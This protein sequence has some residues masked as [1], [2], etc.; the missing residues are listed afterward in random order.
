MNYY[1]RPNDLNISPSLVQSMPHF[2]DI[3]NEKGK[4]I[5][6]G[7]NEGKH[8]LQKTL[9]LAGLAILSSVALAYL[10]IGIFNSAIQKIDTPEE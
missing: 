4:R 9:G 10:A 6:L 8:S 1:T 5:G 2:Y 3:R 7:E